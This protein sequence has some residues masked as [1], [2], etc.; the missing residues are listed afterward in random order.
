MLSSNLSKQYSKSQE[1]SG[2]IRIKKRRIKY[3]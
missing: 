2:M 3:G 1:V